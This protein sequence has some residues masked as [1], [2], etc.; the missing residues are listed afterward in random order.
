M[1]SRWNQWSKTIG[2]HQVR[3]IESGHYRKIFGSTSYFFTRVDREWYV[4]VFDPEGNLKLTEGPFDSLTDGLQ[5][6]FERY[7]RT[8]GLDLTDPS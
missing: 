5:W 7:Q 8:E 1:S 4:D 2:G 6:A 3:K